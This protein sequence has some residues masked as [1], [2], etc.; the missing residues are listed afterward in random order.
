ME[1]NSARKREKNTGRTHLIHGNYGSKKWDYDHHV[2]PPMTSST[3]YRLNSTHRGS[4]GFYEFANGSMDFIKHVPIYIYDRLEEPTRG[5]LEENLAYAEQA[6]MCVSFATGM[7]AISA[8]L[9]VLC[10]SGSQIVAQSCFIWMH[11]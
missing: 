11:I 4:Q 3:T 10:G 6:E 8:V 9:G 2:V 1:I 5:M 7:A